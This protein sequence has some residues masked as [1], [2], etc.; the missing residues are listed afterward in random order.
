MKKIIAVAAFVLW[1]GAGTAHAQRTVGG[2]SPGG[3]GG[4]G[5]GPN[6]GGGGGAAGGGGGGGGSPPLHQYRGDRDRDH[7]QAA[8][9]VQSSVVMPT[10]ETK[11]RNAV[12]SEMRKSGNKED[13]VR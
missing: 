12:I 11:S 8:V 9:G 4:N 10:I 7:R 1:F 5:G 3:G 2:G 6:S 13:Q